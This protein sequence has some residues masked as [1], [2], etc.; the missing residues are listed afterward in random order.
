MLWAQVGQCEDRTAKG[1]VREKSLPSRGDSKGKVLRTDRWG[2][3]SQSSGVG[4]GRRSER[5]QNGWGLGE[6]E[7]LEGGALT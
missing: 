3:N 2:C 4:T 6:H 5:E 7:P 1:G